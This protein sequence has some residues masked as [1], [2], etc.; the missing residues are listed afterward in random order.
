MNDRLKKKAQ[1]IQELSEL[2]RQ[3]A[4]YHESYVTR[5][6]AQIESDD[7]RGY[8]ESIIE[9]LREP[10]LVLDVNMKVL[11][12]N[13]SFYNTFKVTP[14]NTVGSLIYELGN[15]QWEIPSLH[16]LLENILQRNTEFNDYE[17]VHEFESIGRKVMFL[18]AR[19]I[20]R[21]DIGTQTILLAIED[22]TE[23][24]QMEEKLL[25]AS[26][27]DVLTGLTNRR[28]FFAMADKLLKL[29]KRQ[30]NSIF[31]LYIDL[32]GLKTI[33]DKMGHEEGD[34]ALVDAANILT[35][36]YRES[37]IV[38]RIGGD[39]FV[40]VQ[41]GTKVNSTKANSTKVTKAMRSR[42]EEAVKVHNSESNCT[43]KISLSAGMAYSTPETACSIGELL[44][45]GDKAMYEQ[46]RAKR[47]GKT[48]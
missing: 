5:A 9:T 17:V 41:V 24:R 47:T 31:M 33:N 36:T 34:R 19:R 28:G 26:V 20:Y 39:E 12:A 11:S 14:T 29:A 38:A 23:R 7:A 2:R 45:Q 30:G 44:A 48:T 25:A 27:T 4:E 22:V 42:L 10:I 1:L 6:R 37:D 40:V 21:D 16:I 43:Y 8:A 46:K 35:K 32:D 13:R 18:N 3:I 15:K